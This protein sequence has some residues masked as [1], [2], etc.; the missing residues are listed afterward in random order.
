MSGQE[1]NMQPCSSNQAG[2][3]GD[4]DSDPFSLSDMERTVIFND[5]DSNSLLSDEVDSAAGDGMGGAT[6]DA[7]VSGAAAALP[8]NTTGFVKLNSSANRRFKKAMR[9][10]LTRES[11]LQAALETPSDFKRGRSDGNT[12]PQ[13]VAK[14]VR[15]TNTW[16][17][18]P[19][20]N[21]VANS[22]KLGVVPCNLATSPLNASEMSSIQEAVVDTSI[23]LTGGNVNPQFL[24]CRWKNGWLYFICANLATAEWVKLNFDSIKSKCGLDII[25]IEEPE[26]PRLFTIRGYFPDSLELTDKKILATIEAQN[27]NLQATSWKVLDRL[28]N[29]RVVQLVLAVEDVH[30]E[31]LCQLHGLISY[32]F[33][34]LRLVLRFTNR[35]V[36]GTGASNSSNATRRANSLRQR[37]DPRERLALIEHT[38]TNRASNLPSGHSHDL[39][40]RSNSCPSVA[41]AAGNSRVAGHDNPFRK[42]GNP[43]GSGSSVDALFSRAPNSSTPKRHTAST[44]DAPVAVGS[45]DDGNNG[46]LNI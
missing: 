23:E 10:G 30:Y 22:V 37:I 7:G 20:Y 25:L 34:Q 27:A 4:G 17:V 3:Q 11:A 5:L 38:A 41:E 6:A 40:H 2:F 42:I 46:G 31:K 39:N 21:D 32:R 13:Q 24:G 26:F 45:K 8:N 29:G 19:S 15:G 28:N 35:N 36:D 33:G 18:A 12:P 14:R 1:L 9:A 44:S 16:Q 43:A